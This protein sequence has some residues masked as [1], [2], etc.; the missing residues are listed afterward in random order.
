MLNC[1]ITEHASSFDINLLYSQT[2]IPLHRKWN[3]QP[4]EVHYTKSQRLTPDAKLLVTISVRLI[5]K[6]VS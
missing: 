2:S 4:N 5:C 3:N 1:L 6:Y